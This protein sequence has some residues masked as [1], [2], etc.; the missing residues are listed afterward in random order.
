[1]HLPLLQVNWLPKQVR[2]GWLQISAGS[3][4]LSPQSSSPS[5][6]Q[7]A[8]THRWLVRHRNASEKRSNVVSTSSKKSFT[9]F[10]MFQDIYLHLQGLANL[11]S[12]DGC[13]YARLNACQWITS[14]P[15]CSIYEWPRN[16]DDLHDATLY[17]DQC[18]R[19]IIGILFSLSHL[20]DISNWPDWEPALECQLL[21]SRL[22]L[23]CP[24][25][26]KIT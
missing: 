18:S 16:F 25:S 3:S 24:V 14:S 26:S 1:M 23:W 2:L 11:T 20:I 19:V 9:I 4:E 15:Q 13:S 8:G 17:H 12:I 5:Q 10:Q 22:R 7:N 21:I 6:C